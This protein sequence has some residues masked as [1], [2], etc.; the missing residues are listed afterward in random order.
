[1]RINRHT[2]L[3]VL[4][5]LMLL[6]TGCGTDVYVGSGV[7]VCTGG[8]GATECSDGHDESQDTDTTTTT[9]GT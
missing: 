8:D 6:A 1:M 2:I 3:Y 7:E 4:A 5:C 9:T